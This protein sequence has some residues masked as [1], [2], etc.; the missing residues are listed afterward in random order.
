MTAQP[1]LTLTDISK[2][3]GATQ[4]LS[5]VSLSFPRGSV[6]AIVGHN[7]AGK[8]TL[9]RIL[10]GETKPDTGSVEIDG[11]LVDIDSPVTAARYGVGFVHQETS[12]CPDLTVYENMFLGQERTRL[13]LLAWKE[14][15]AQAEELMTLLDLR[16]LGDV[17]VSSLDVTHRQL[18][19][20]ATALLANPRILI[21]DEPNSA[22][23]RRET[24]ALFA[25]VRALRERGH[26]VLYISHRLREVREIADSIVVM[27]DGRVAGRM[28]A[29]SSVTQLAELLLGTPTVSEAPRVNGL[30][31]ADLRESH[32]GPNAASLVAD[33]WSDE[34]G[35]FSDVALSVQPGE[36]V[37]IAGLEG[38]GH[39]ELL[40]SLAGLRHARGR[41]EVVGKPLRRPDV[42][43]L[44]ERGVA[45]LSPDRA[46]ESV[47]QGM[48]VEHNLG[49]GL[50]THWSRFGFIRPSV[51]RRLAREQITRYGITGQADE[52]VRA[53]SGGNQQKVALARL[54]A[55]KPHVLLLE[56]PTRGV[57]LGAKLQ[58]YGVLAALKEAG[59]AIVVTSPEFDELVEL[60]D[61]VLVIAGG[62]LRTE[63]DG[64]GLTEARLL[65]EAAA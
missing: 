25:R 34:Q 63:L 65:E 35:A 12:L 2:R 52:P 64:D 33:R 40:R 11:Q 8:S 55:A 50:V 10:H 47:F 54:L 53:L 15:R 38:S 30:A 17:R 48:S 6:Q 43:R 37:G 3:F 1:L 62:R 31:R 56:E 5:N 13:R 29:T 61:R 24:E 26:L 9:M 4:A 7:G 49:I 28:D 58:I 27:R 60:S 51:L 21:L 19:E 14:M 45:Y 46:G 42:R 36:I 39:R 59:T 32:S 22:L 41:L 20:V 44:L 57:D 23:S 18:T 16:D